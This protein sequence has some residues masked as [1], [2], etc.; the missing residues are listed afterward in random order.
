M[1]AEALIMFDGAMP[2]SSK[3]P[4]ACIQSKP[5]CLKRKTSAAHD[6]PKPITSF[7]IESS[8]H[9]R[10]AEQ[11]STD[12]DRWLTIGNFE[13]ESVHRTL[14]G[15]VEVMAFLSFGQSESPAEK[16]YAN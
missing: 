16:A 2:W 4:P 6:E 9:A 1:T 11:R 10:I 7:R 8:L 5:D 3:E 14:F 15:L 12:V 13:D